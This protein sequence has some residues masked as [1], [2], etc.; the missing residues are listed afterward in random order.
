MGR[1]ALIIV[2]GITFSTLMYSSALRNAVFFSSSRNVQSH[3]INQ[4]YNI[5]QSAVMVAIDDARSDINSI[6]NPDKD[7][8]Y[9]Y[10]APN[11]FAEWE[12]LHGSYN[13][14][15]TNQGDSLLTLTSRG[16]YNESEYNVK[17]GLIYSLGLWDPI[18]DQAVHAEN[19]IQLTGGA[20]ISGDAAINSIQSNAVYLGSSTSIDSTLFTGPGGVTD[21]VVNNKHKVGMVFITC[22]KNWTIRCPYFQTSPCMPCLRALF[23]VHKPLRLRIM[24]TITY[25][26][27]HLQAEL[28]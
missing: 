4:A 9:I 25:R 5:A 2:V 27:Y 18:I 21:V 22:P 14:T 11:V 13:I 15:A 7:S 20:I 24:K 12:D 10:P 26:K 16:R 17:V 23:T 8:T 1:Y 3:S 19:K 6:F 28:H